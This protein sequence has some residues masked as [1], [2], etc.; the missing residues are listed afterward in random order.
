LTLAFAE[1]ASVTPA[2][3]SRAATSGYLIA[4][5]RPPG[6]SGRDSDQLAFVIHS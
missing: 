1:D 2:Y 4:S 5:Y 3:A 6:V